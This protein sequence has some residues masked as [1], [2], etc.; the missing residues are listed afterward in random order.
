MMTFEEQGLRIDS[1]NK[2]TQT[3]VRKRE[4]VMHQ[5]HD[6]NEMKNLPHKLTGYKF[7]RLDKLFEEWDALDD[8]CK[9]LSKV[10]DT[11]YAKPHISDFCGD[12]FVCEGMLPD[13]TPTSTDEATA[14]KM[15]AD[16][17]ARETA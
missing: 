13:G 7:A 12:E 5:V 17:Y 14:L 8:L 15:L 3:I 4:E 1:I 6:L 11:L 9:K 10:N 16:Y 2:T